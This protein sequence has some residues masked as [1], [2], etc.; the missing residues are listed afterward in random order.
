[1]TAD[2]GESLQVGEDYGGLGRGRT[3]QGAL[4]SRC[5]VPGRH[6]AGGQFASCIFEVTGVK[7]VG[8]GL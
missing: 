3:M 6:G 1:M 4:G 5:M 8:A 2:M 7:R